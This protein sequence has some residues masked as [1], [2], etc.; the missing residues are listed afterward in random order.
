MNIQQAAQAV[1]FEAIRM[2]KSHIQNQQFNGESYAPIKES[3]IRRRKRSKSPQALVDTSNLIDGFQFYINS[4]NQ[5][6]VSIT[7]TN[8]AQDR[9]KY[10]LKFHES[11][12]NRYLD[13]PGGDVV[14]NTGTFE[15]PPIRQV[16]NLSA[17]ELLELEALF[18]RELNR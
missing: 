4:A 1:A 3:T 11:A 8:L 14:K 2:F 5:N 12:Y 18:Y 9:G 17:S 6:G 15:D 16:M 10:Y 13:T 7:I